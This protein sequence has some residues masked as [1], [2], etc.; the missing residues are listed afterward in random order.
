M[1]SIKDHDTQEY[2][3]DQASILKIENVARHFTSQVAGLEGEDYWE[4]LS[5]LR[6]YSQERRRERYQIIFVWKVLQGLVQGYTLTCSDHP[7][8]GRC[9]NICPYNRN[10]PSAVRN[11]REAT[12][13]VKGAKLFNLLPRALR[14][15]QSGTVDQFKAQLDKWLEVVPDQP[16]VPGRLR[17]AKTNS[18]L[19]QVSSS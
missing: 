19:D 9:V 15:I 4:R 6:M 5:S 18:L 11:A 2:K 10:S 14:D 7:R 17:A 3:N 16:T 1:L 13:A 8:R 12:L